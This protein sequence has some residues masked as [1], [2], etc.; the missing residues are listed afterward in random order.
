MRGVKMKKFQIVLL[1]A[2]AVASVQGGVLQTLREKVTRKPA[3]APVNTAA[4]TF[5]EG[6][7][8]QLQVEG[9]DTAASVHVLNGLI[10]DYEKQIASMQGVKSAESK[11][12][13]G[14]LREQIG[15]LQNKIKE[16]QPQ[17][18]DEAHEQELADF[19]GGHEKALNQVGLGN[20][21]ENRWSWENVKSFFKSSTKQNSK[22][23]YD[24]MNEK[25]AAVYN[26]QDF[27]VNDVLKSIDTSAGDFVKVSQMKTKM[28]M[29][30][31]EGLGG[32]GSGYD[33]EGRDQAL[34]KA[35]RERFAA[36]KVVE[37]SLQ[38]IQQKRNIEENKLR[39]SENI[40][41]VHQ[42]SKEMGKV[43]EME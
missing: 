2:F 9:A 28:N 29:Q 19:F 8:K 26:D 32:Q 43:L 42:A 15:Q 38:E 33:K 10:V 3:V 31:S 35:R 14:V 30:D 13:I 16:I 11:R 39:V 22:K 41:K 23:S 4:Q 34:L 20:V 6:R 5:H 18:S 37:D 25:L 1:G 27:D 7:L 12:Q 24:A 21:K 17:A 40:K 36:R